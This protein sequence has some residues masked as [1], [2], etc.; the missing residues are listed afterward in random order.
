MGGCGRPMAPKT[1]RIY[2]DDS[3]EKEYGS[4]TSRYFVYAGVI[5]DRADEDAI[6]AE[7]DEL[8]RAAFGTTDVEIKSNWLRIDRERERRYFKPFGITPAR[9]D[10][11][12]EEVGRLMTS[13]RLTYLAAAIDKPAMLEKYPNPWYPSATAYQFLLQRYERHCADAGA[14]GLITVD[15]MDG[16][17]PKNN[18]WRDLLRAH[19]T[20]LKKD[21]CPLTKMTF[22]NMPK[23]PLFA[24]SKGLNLLQLADLL[25]YNVFRHFREHGD[26]WETGEAMPTYKHLDPLLPRFRLGPDGVIEGWG[27]VKWPTARE[28]KWAVE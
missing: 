22:P 20:R 13:D 6:V 7:I 17:S 16:S 15:D 11:F 26:A 25:A 4:N 1:F 10:Q 8:K 3:G 24:S 12:G 9:L 14:S 28:G 19:H 23:A 2:I 5:V 18:Q 21:G 27:I